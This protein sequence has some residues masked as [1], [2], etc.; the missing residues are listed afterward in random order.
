LESNTAQ[1]IEACTVGDINLIKSID[2]KDLIAI[3][4]SAQRNLIIIA[5]FHHQYHLVEY[6]LTIGFDINSTNKKG[7][8]VLMYA[9]TKCMELEDFSFMTWLLKHGADLHHKDNFGKD[10]F[11]YANNIGNQELITFLNKNK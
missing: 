3:R 9:K 8:S 5:A 4:D 6:L 11:Y 10:I 1:I 7:T 2:P